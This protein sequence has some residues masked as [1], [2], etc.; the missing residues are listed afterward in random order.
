MKT[1][2]ITGVGRGLGRFTALKLAQA[3]HRIILSARTL[4][5]AEET[6][7]WI[8]TQAPHAN[9]VPVGIDL[10]S[11]QE[12]RESAARLSHETLHVLFHIAGIMQ[13]SPTRRLTPDGLE[14]TLAV[15]ALAP[16]LLTY[17]LLPCLKRAG[18]SHVIT[19]SSRLHL[20]KSIGPEVNF[21][22]DDPNLDSDYHPTV[23]YKNSKLAVLWWTYTLAEKLGPQGIG[24]HATCPGFVPETAS[25]S[26]HGLYRFMLKHVLPLM[27][28]AQTIE[29]ATTHFAEL[30][31]HPPQQSGGF[32][33]EGKAIPSSPESL[34]RQKAARFWEWA[35]STLGISGNWH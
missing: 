22:F 10:S 23:A 2:L 26:V 31:E 35:C 3:G 21:R 27:P 7:R 1:V 6:A 24:A 29:G 28:F 17:E 33:A 12:I 14:E 15:N 8:R 25:A 30:V 11:F 16:L 19:V 18:S 9:L 34:D 20:P 4:P 13:Q 5:A 32:W